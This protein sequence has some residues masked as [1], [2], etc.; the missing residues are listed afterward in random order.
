M[1]YNTSYIAASDIGLKT[2]ERKDSTEYSLVS[3]M[4]QVITNAIAQN[5]LTIAEAVSKETLIPAN[6]MD[7][8]MTVD[9][10]SQQRAEFLFKALMEE[11]END[12]KVF[13][14]FLDILSNL[15]LNKLLIKSLKSFLP[16]TSE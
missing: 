8:I 14:K 15:G 4:S 5:S 9:Y 13:Y 12:T 3:V 6:I 1:F 2:G 11:I 10:I 16:S 7:R